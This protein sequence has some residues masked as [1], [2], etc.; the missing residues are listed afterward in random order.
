MPPITRLEPVKAMMVTKIWLLDQC[1]TVVWAASHWYIILISNIYKKALKHLPY[2]WIYTSHSHLF[3]LKVTINLPVRCM[4]HQACKEFVGN[5]FV[6]EKTYV[7]GAHNIDNCI[8][9]KKSILPLALL[10]LSRASSLACFIAFSAF[11]FCGHK[12]ILLYLRSETIEILHHTLQSD[13]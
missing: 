3:E 13:S 5:F 7:C 4:S 9:L 8:M 2:G 6:P 1:V 10:Y 12:G 11:V